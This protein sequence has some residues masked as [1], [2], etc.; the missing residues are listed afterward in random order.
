MGIY[1]HVHIHVHGLYVSVYMKL[2]IHICLCP[3]PVL[4]QKH[5]DRTQALNLSGG[6]QEYPMEQK[7]P[8]ALGNQ[9]NLNAQWQPKC[10]H[11]SLNQWLQPSFPL[12]KSMP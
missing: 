11:N 3:G 7:A 5:P 9:D 8:G 12:G 2:Q 1:T 4:E 10:N 6:R